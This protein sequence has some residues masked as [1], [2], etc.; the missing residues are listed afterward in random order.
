M[1]YNTGILIILGG[2]VMNIKSKKFI[3][4]LLAGAMMAGT[5]SASAAWEFSG[6]DTSNPPAYGKIYNEKINGNYTCKMKVEPI[7]EEDIEWVSE[8]FEFAYPHAG[9]ERL[10]LEKNPQ[11]ITRYNGQ[12]PQ[13]ETRFKDFMW[14]VAGA[15]RIYQ[16][17][18]TNIPGFGW[19]WDFGNE[20]FGIDDTAVFVPT[21]RFAETTEEHKPFGIATFDLNGKLVSDEVKDF[22]YGDYFVEFD[23]DVV[24]EGP[25]AGGYAYGPYTVELDDEGK[26]TKQIVDGTFFSE[27]NLSVTDANGQYVVTDEEIAAMAGLI[28]TKY[29]TGP[30]FYGEDPTKNVAKMYID[31]LLNDNDADAWFWDVDTVINDYKAEISW[32]APQYEMEEPY[33]YYQFLVVNG[34]VFD[35]RNDLPRVYRYTGG[36]ASPKVEWKYQWSEE[37]HPH[38]V[39][40]RKYLDGQPASYMNGDPIYRI[41]TG[42]F[43]NVYTKVTDTEIQHWLKDE[44]GGDVMIGVTSKVDAYYGGVAEGFVPA[45]GYV[46]Y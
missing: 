25:T 23:K 22:Y 33:N 3:V 41:P 32:T 35:G 13:W 20:A 15:H 38:Q 24:Y 12:F 1:S 29:V 43:G 2:F 6:Y 5:V 36:K 14:E 8:G 16:R 9:Y 46:A 19:S 34:L 17:Q 42:E 21:T 26:P 10:Y 27:E 40:E 28:S 30:S 31:L 7:A 45:S 4:S 37:V 11:V 44:R 39:I 18:Q